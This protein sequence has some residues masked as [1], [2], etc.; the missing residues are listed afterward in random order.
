MKGKAEQTSQFIVERVA[1]IFN[2]NGYNGT[3][4]SD[5]T[6]ATGLTKGAVYG[7]FKN[8]EDLAFAA[9]KFNVDLI[10]GKIK[11]VLIQIDSPTEQLKEL[12]N[13]YRSYLKN[14]S[15]IGGCP[16]LNIGVDANH[17]NSE[18]L[19]RVQLVIEKL[20]YYIQRMI[21]TGQEMGE[22]KENIDAPFYARRIYTMIQGAVFM[23]VTMKNDN[24]IS[25]VMDH[26]DELI[27]H[28]LVK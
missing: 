5:I 16:I 2:R 20:Q 21:E 27:T 6:K 23:T 14:T 7:N 10:V 13:F 25:E 28:D 3:S 24:Y 1:P 9:F 15:E 12:V 26:V 11:S 18:L 17:Q 8:K 4:M 22:L 19:H